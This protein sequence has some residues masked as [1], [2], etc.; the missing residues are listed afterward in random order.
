MT[1]VVM[2]T[3]PVAARPL[4]SVYSISSPYCCL[5]MLHIPFS[6][7]IFYFFYL[8]E[9]FIPRLKAAGQ[10]L[11][12][13]IG[14]SWVKPSETAS[15]VKQTS[16]AA[17]RPQTVARRSFHFSMRINSLNSPHLLLLHPS[18]TATVAG[19]YMTTSQHNRHM[20]KKSESP[21]CQLRRRQSKS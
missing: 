5:K 13:P 1:C 18:L 15:P 12:R 4:P 2:S 17:T 20:L 6:V 3:T 21:Q 7:F 10:W 11:S 16:N 8:L 19:R 14:Y 9:F